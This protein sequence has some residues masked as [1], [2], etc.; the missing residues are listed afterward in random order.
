MKT[1]DQY[2][3]S[4]Q[5]R[6]VRLFVRGQ[7]IDNPLEHPLIA[8]SIRTIA[9]SYRMAHEPEHRELFTAHSRFI[10]DRVNRFTHV[11][12]SPDDLLKKVQMQRTLGRYTGTCFQRCVGMDAINALYSTTFDMDAKEGTAFHAR[13][14]EFVKHV[15]REDLMLCGAMTDPKGD[16]KK[17]PLEQP[18]MYLRVVER[19]KDSIIVRGAK[20]HQTGVVN[21]HMIVAMPGR[22]L[23]ADETQFA[24]SFAIPVD[25]KGI[26]MVYGR[27]PSDDRRMGCD[28]DQGNAKYGGQEAIVL[29]ED[30]EVPMDHVFMLGQTGWAAPLVDMFAGYH[31]Q[32]YGG[33]KPGNGDVLIGAAA[34][35]AKMNG[36]DK[37]PHVRDKLVEMTHLNETMHAGGLACST[38]CTKTAAGTYMVD[39]LLANVCKH[40]VTRFPYEMS[41]L[42]ED[43]AGGLMVT[44]PSAEDFDHPEYGE[45]LRKIVS[46][47]RGSDE[48]RR[49]ALRLVETMTI[50]STAVAFRT[51]SMHGAGSPQAQRMRIEQQGDF[52]AKMADARRIAGVK[53]P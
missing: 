37:V 26:T 2:L 22:A 16:R 51:E 13:F 49:R 43:L 3:A 53:A 42:A 1:M 46:G 48:D 52:E 34:L 19:N 40:N 17:P 24:V 7:R 10:N 14:T 23:S 39:P 28:I 33:C 27:Q 47:A 35:V 50:G 41:R 32:S 36:V 15:Q 4:L 25:A 18:E 30:V 9:E 38:K 20:M 5:A 45:L 31:R 11:F 44:L 12:E 6:N 29:F 21:S 8:P